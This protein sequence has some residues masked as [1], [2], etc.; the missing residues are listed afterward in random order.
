MFSF[1]YQPFLFLGS[2]DDIRSGWRSLFGALRGIRLPGI[3][4]GATPADAYE[5]EADKVRQLRVLLDIF[6][7]FLHTGKDKNMI[8]DSEIQN[9]SL[10]S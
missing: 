2:T 6:E 3:P 8:F 1:L 5:L 7:A 10:S 4:N 9:I